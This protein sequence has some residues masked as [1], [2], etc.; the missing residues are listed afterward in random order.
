MNKGKLKEMIGQMIMVGFRGTELDCNDKIIKDIRDM[1]VGGTILFD[2]D[3]ET[4][5]LERNIKNQ[6]QLKKLNQGLQDFVRTP[7]FIAVDQE[8]GSV[9]RLMPA[10]GYEKTM[11]HAELG[12]RND[13]ETTRI[14]AGRIAS[15]VSDSGFNIN[16]APVVDLNINKLNPIIGKKGRSISYDPDVVTKHALIFIEEHLKQNILPCI[17]HFMGHGSS[18]SDSHL[19]FVDVTVCYDEKE[20]LPFKTLI[21][22]GVVDMV[23]TAH[24]FHRRYDNAHPFTLSENVIKGILRKEM[25]FEGVVVSDDMQMKAIAE[26]Y[27]FEEAVL[28]A[29]MAGIDII[30]ISNNIN[31]DPEMH[32]K[33]IN[34][35]YSA[36]EDGKL[37]FQRIEES[38]E[39]I[40]SLKN[41]I[42]IIEDM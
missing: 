9:A 37:P 27:D 41:K 36:V 14:N 15:Q 31:Y 2:Y 35:I 22:K 18:K 5:S 30:L 42:G 38:F 19:G 3:T 26:N 11:S 13:I 20:K 10:H 24:L 7:L 28:L 32:I 39:R 4:K 16:L 29:V 12:Q 17:K 21:K 40:T 6:E 8:G 23:M 34:T 1:N 33:A 25:G